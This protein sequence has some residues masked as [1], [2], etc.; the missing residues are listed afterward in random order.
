MSMA[1]SVASLH[2]EV[3]SIAID[4]LLSVVHIGLSL[5]LL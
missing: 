1:L 4:L 2:S 5:L 3:D